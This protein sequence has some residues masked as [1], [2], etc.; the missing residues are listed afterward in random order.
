MLSSVFAQIYIQQQDQELQPRNAFTNSILTLAIEYGIDIPIFAVLYYKD[1]KQR[2]IDNIT[3][4]KNISVIK[5]DVKK[6]VAA[7]S[8]SELMYD[9][10]KVSSQ[11]QLL[12]YANVEPFQA[13]MISSLLAWTAF[14][15][16][17]NISLKAFSL[18]E[19]KEFLWYCG[20]ILSITFVNSLIFL[21]DPETRVLYT[22]STVVATSGL[23]LLSVSFLMFKQRNLGQVL[24]SNRVFVPVAI[25][26]FLWFIAE[27]L[28][29]YYQIGLQIDVPF[30][31]VAD[32]FWII[33][34]LFLIIHVYY[35]FKLLKKNKMKNETDTIKVYHIVLISLVLAAVL[36]YSL[37][38]IFGID[39]N[40]TLLLFSQKEALGN[41]ISI[42][43]PILDAI[44]I[45]P[46][47]AI[48]WDL[49]R[50]GPQFTHWIM[51]SLFIVMVTAGDIGFGYSYVLGEEI[52]ELANDNLNAGIY[53]IN[54][55]AS[56]LPSG[57]YFYKIFSGSFSESKK[58]LLLK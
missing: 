29:G 36:G 53:S 55:D 56:D 28:W 17:V 38:I 26:I 54:W 30:P 9:V 35:V 45:V 49:K 41:I 57:V 32:A 34:Y 18:F 7:L 19:K 16:L 31:S 14:F 22:N 3:G 47:V 23:A 21:S 25:G 15:I 44:L 8:L 27:V 20:L 37:S 42:A 6:L 24:T 1:N 12:Q 40:N 2:Y 39:I 43:Y 51:L 4:G 33:G 13:A 50:A 48:L 52:A 10:I 58:M 11:Y 5:A 46:A